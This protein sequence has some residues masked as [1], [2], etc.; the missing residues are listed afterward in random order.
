MA[1]P[2][3]ILQAFAASN[4]SGIPD[5]ITPGY[6][7]ENR[8]HAPLAAIFFLFAIAT[9]LLILRSAARLLLVK[10]F[11]LDDWLAVLTVVCSVWIAAAPAHLVDDQH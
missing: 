7:A 6:L 5:G 8:D 3:D 1:I 10:Q 4:H 2:A 9:I 11:G